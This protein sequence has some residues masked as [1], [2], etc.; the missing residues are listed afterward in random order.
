MCNKTGNTY[1]WKDALRVGICREHYDLVKYYLHGRSIKNNYLE[2]FLASLTK[3][4]K[5]K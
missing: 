1:K 2:Y 3:H 5:K 4:R